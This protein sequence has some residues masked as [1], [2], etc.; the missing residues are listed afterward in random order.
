[1]FEHEHVDQSRH[2]GRDRNREND[3]EASEQE[4]DHG[5]GYERDERRE[6][7]RVPH[8]V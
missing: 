3:R 5:D 8:D 7:D 6:A 2:R 1:M 4:P